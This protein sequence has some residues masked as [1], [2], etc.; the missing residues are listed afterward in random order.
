MANQQLVNQLPNIMLENLE[1]IKIETPVDKIIRQIR[2]LITSG[3]IQ[4][5]DKLP[6]ER[7]LAEHLGIGRKYVRDAINKLEF[8]GILRTVPQSGTYVAGLG[9]TALEGLISDVLSLEK[10]DFPSLVETRVLLEREAARQAAIRRSEDDIIAIRNAM[11]A[12]EKRVLDGVNGMEEDLMFH[13]KIAEASNNSVLRS[14]MLIITPDVINSFLKMKVCGEDKIRRTLVEHKNI[15]Q[16]IIDRAPTEAVKAM[17][18]HLW[19]VLEFSET[20]RQK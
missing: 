19:D 5:G 1:K 18:E 8:Y 16:A 20:L 2:S 11:V 13:L 12:Y 4:P 7:K 10:K 14:L 9:I 17:D 6:P 15:L 3:Q